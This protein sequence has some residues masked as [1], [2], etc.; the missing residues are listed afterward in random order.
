MHKINQTVAAHCFPTTKQGALESHSS[1]KLLFSSQR[2][3]EFL[4][5][6]A[7]ECQSHDWRLLAPSWPVRARE[8]M[9][10]RIKA[11][12]CEVHCASCFSSCAISISPSQPRFTSLSFRFPLSVE[13]G[14]RHRISDDDLVGQIFTAVL[15]HLCSVLPLEPDLS[16]VFGGF[17]RQTGTF[18]NI[19]QRP[20][21]IKKVLNLK[22]PTL[23][24]LRQ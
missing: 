10:G 9:S 5:D 3:P 22:L 23:I 2:L 11:F 6:S 15:F 1:I 24:C 4:S 18:E 20:Q 19:P 12:M 16:S 13:N 7:L 14:S 21:E 8:V 17:G